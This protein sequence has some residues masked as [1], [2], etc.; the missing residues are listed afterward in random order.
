[1]LCGGGG[2]ERG[3]L[4]VHLL[5]CLLYTYSAPSDADLACFCVTGM[6]A[7][8]MLSWREERAPYDNLPAGR[9][10]ISGTL[11]SSRFMSIRSCL[12]A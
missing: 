9:P 7:G 3:H 2:G 4:R 1:M 10:D 6:E 5:V 12:L 8:V 11:A